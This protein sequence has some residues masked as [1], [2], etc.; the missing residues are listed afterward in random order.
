MN[1]LSNLL[2]LTQIRFMI[3]VQLRVAKT[4]AMVCEGCK[5]IVNSAYHYVFFP[6]FPSALRCPISQPHHLMSLLVILH[7]LRL[8]LASWGF[9]LVCLH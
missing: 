4:F 7:L 3:A 6:D 2:M 1:D 8:I 9:V 5:F